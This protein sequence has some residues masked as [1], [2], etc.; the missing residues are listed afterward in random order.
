MSLAA[1]VA[2]LVASAAFNTALRAA[3]QVPAPERADRL[4]L[5]SVSEVKGWISSY[6]LTHH[7]R[8][9]ASLGEAA[10]AA[11]VGPGD[12]SSFITDPQ[13][14]KAM[15]YTPGAGSSY[16]ICVDFNVAAKYR[17]PVARWNH[18]AGEY[19]FTF[20]AREQGTWRTPRL[21]NQWWS[22]C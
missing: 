16:R 10:S 8:L 7:Q 14:K 19:C 15:R 6:Y 17:A 20:D 9:P 3:T 22:G 11:G 13:T 21:D 5:N 2:A 12:A 4:R 1:L 18:D